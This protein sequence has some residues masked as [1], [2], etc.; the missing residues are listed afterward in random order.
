[1]SSVSKTQKTVRAVS[2]LVLAV[3]AVFWMIPVV[4]LI[5]NSFKT[6]IEFVS[7]YSNAHTPAEYLRA[8]FPKSLNFGSYIALFTGEGLSTTANL[9]TMI[10]NSLV[11]SISHTAIVVVVSSLAAYAFERLK[12]PDGDKI[13]WALFYISLIPASASMLPLFKICN[14]FNWLNT[15]NALIWPGTASVMSVFLLRNFMTSIPRAL[16][17]AARIDGASSL[18]IYL[19]II[20]PAIK[21]VLMIVGLNAFRGAWNDYLWPSIVMT[22]PSNQTLTAGMALLSNQYGNNQWTNLLAGT[23][24]SMIVPLLLYLTCQ[25]YF[26]EGIS[27]RAAVKG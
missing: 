8:V 5:L 9:D 11:V 22:N 18:Q 16:D 24:I 12:F 4:W 19:K 21:P 20:V 10:L 14:S 6:N 3:V 13:F 15:L 23:V 26:L 17:E 27:I 2:T 1:M 25:K 7:G